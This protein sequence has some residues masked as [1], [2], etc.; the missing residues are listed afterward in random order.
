M[1]FPAIEI[2]AD[3]GVELYLSYGAEFSV[4]YTESAQE[5]I[6]FSVEDGTLKVEQR[7][8]IVLM[9]YQ[10]K[11][12]SVTVPSGNPVSSVA[13]DVDGNFDCTVTG[14]YGSLDFETGRV[15]G[16]GSQRFGKQRFARRARRGAGDAGGQR[17]AID[18][19]F[20]RRHDA[21]RRQ[22][23]RRVGRARLRRQTGFRASLLRYARRRLR[24]GM[25]R[26]IL[27]GPRRDEGDRRRGQFAEGRITARAARACRAFR[28]EGD[29]MNIERFTVG[30]RVRRPPARLRYLRAGRAAQGRLSDRARHVR[31]QGTLRGLYALSGG[32]RFCRRGARSSRP[33]RQRFV[34][35]R[36]GLVSGQ[37]GERF[38]RGRRAGDRRS[39]SALS[40]P[41]VL[42]FG[43]SMGSMVVR[44]YIQEHDG[45]IDSLV[46]CG[47]PSKNSLA[48]PASPS[49]S[50]SRR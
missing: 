39:E 20:G 7:S 12:I 22:F 5:Q 37:K 28:A 46:V 29:T 14:E 34:R 2:D 10:S 30:V 8:D 47:S 31:A 35:R 38:G 3:G 36:P 40:R 27:R 16:R 32:E 48:A 17:G 44:C 1:F 19:D 23:F 43:H 6:S 18:R 33:R 9:G 25:R 50:P 41:A 42:L 26:R 13:A 49:R 45:D 21:R 4:T 24:R 11:R 15:A